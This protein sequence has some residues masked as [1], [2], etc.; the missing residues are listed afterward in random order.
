MIK[1]I[2]SGWLAGWLLGKLKEQL[3]LNKPRTINLD[4]LLTLVAQTRVNESANIISSIET[5]HTAIMY[6]YVY[7][8][9]NDSV[10]DPHHFGFQDLRASFAFCFMRYPHSCLG[11][12]CQRRKR[13]IS[14]YSQ[15]TSTMTLQPQDI[16]YKSK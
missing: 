15:H 4:F 2:R 8:R 1:T 14:I 9:N 6:V 11:G 10:F 3:M 12:S 16:L 7:T 5:M 13:D